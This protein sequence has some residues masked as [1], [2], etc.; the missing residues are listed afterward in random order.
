MNTSPRSVRPIVS[1]PVARNTTE[2]VA[3]A[4]ANVGAYRLA[5]VLM[6]LQLALRGGQINQPSVE[7]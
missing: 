7:R 4:S 3:A 5:D 6:D 2:A 1:A